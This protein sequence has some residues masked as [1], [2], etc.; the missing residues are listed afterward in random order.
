MATTNLCLGQHFVHNEENAL[1]VLGTAQKQLKAQGLG[2]AAD[3]WEYS[4]HYD[5]SNDRPHWLDG[6]RWLCWR[7]TCNKYDQYITH[8][9]VFGPASP[10]FYRAIGL[11]PQLPWQD[12]N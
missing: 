7:S 5:W 4:P 6:P 10:T 11:L 8:T 3:V 12:E 1:I 2:S 9:F